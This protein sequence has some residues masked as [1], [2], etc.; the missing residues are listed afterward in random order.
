MT[1]EKIEE[2]LDELM[3]T[4]DENLKAV[5]LTDIKLAVRDYKEERDE[6]E[7]VKDG[8]IA[9]LGEDIAER[10][11]TIDELRIANSSLAERY[12]KIMAKEDATQTE[13]ADEAYEI[14]EL[15]KRFD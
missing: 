3:T 10:D 12:S 8:E 11:N 6:T 1:V 13:E 15:I 9:K 4:E 14:D 7:T 5:K 2:M